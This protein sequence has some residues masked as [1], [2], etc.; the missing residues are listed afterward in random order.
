MPWLAAPALSPL[1]AQA[2]GPLPLH[3]RSSWGDPCHPGLPL[4]SPGPWTKHVAPWE[5][6]LWGRFRAVSTPP[7]SPTS[8]SASCPR[9]FGKT[10]EVFQYGKV[11]K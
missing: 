6:A 11:E 4:P 1:P 9:F 5:H 7:A 2:R 3:L 10:A 8:T